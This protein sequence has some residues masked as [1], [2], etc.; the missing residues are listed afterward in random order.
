M[1]VWVHTDTDTDTGIDQY[2]HQR[3]KGSHSHSNCNRWCI[4]SLPIIH[5]LSLIS[6]VI[7]LSN[8]AMVVVCMGVLAQATR[9]LYRQ[10]DRLWQQAPIHCETTP[11]LTP[12]HFSRHN[13]VLQCT[14]L[15]SRRLH[16]YISR[17]HS[18]RPGHNN[19]IC[20]STHWAERKLLNTYSKQTFAKAVTSLGVIAQV[21]QVYRFLCHLT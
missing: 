11:L 19:G 16:R 12:N 20:G 21:G 15:S 1:C 13:H 3:H 6:V 2:Q 9:R 8:P 7:T 14:L 17:S 10:G 5:V 4:I 18:R